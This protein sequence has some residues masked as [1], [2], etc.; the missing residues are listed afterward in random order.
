MPQWVKG[1]SGNPNGRPKRKSFRDYFD[2]KEE[3][4]LINRIK[5]EIKGE[6][7]GDIVKMTIEHLFGKPKQNIE[8]DASITLPKPLLNGE[9]N[10]SDNTSDKETTETEQK[11]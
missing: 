10:G 4:A 7:K 1:Q 2:E 3:E 6:G 9:S 8:M 11:D 5:Q